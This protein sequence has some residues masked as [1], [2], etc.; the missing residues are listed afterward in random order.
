MAI[1]IVSWD[2]Y[3]RDTHH[4]PRLLPIHTPIYQRKGCTFIIWASKHILSTSHRFPLFCVL[5]D[6]PLI[7]LIIYL[8]VRG[9]DDSLSK[10]NTLFKINGS[11]QWLCLPFF[12]KKKRE[13]FDQQG[14]KMTQSVK[15]RPQP[16]QW[17]LTRQ[18]WWDVMIVILKG[19]K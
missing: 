10:T 18:I 8:S 3:R 19:K 1:H 12:L 13:D 9:K 4:F 15:R 11:D 2:A 6:F 16:N 17:L 5:Y 14:Q 7:I